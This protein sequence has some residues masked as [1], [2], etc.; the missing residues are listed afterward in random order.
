MSD[1]YTLGPDLDLD[2]DVVHE[3][4]GTRLTEQ[5]AAELAE[6]RHGRPSLA[7]G[8]VHSPQITFRL[9]EAARDKAVER[10][11]AEGRTVSDLARDALERYLAS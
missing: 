7:R 5:R 11:A 6:V 10:A 8:A 2:V 1:A 9:T 4:D 3:P